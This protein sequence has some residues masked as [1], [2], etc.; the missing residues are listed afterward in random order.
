MQVR[1]GAALAMAGKRAEALQKLEPYLAQHPE[2]HERH[3]IALRMLYEARA[4]GKPDQIART[5]T[6]RCS[7]RWSAAYAAAKGPQ[8]ALVEQWQRVMAARLAGQTAVTNSTA[9]APTGV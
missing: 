5:R 3:F 4:A 8:Q 7:P 1:L 9:A 6:A 2:D